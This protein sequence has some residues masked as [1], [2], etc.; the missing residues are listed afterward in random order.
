MIKVDY[1]EE[2]RHLITHLK[3]LPGIGPRSAERIALWLLRSPQSP[4]A[5]L[6]RA[7]TAASAGI[8]ARAA[9]PAMPASVARREMSAKSLICT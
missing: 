7:L 5:D 1:P 6:A 4:S 3:R 2:L 8:P 9:A